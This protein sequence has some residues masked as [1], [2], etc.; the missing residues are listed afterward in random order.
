[1]EHETKQK[2]TYNLYDQKCLDTLICIALWFCGCFGLPSEH[3]RTFQTNVSKPFFSISICDPVNQSICFV[4]KGKHLTQFV[5]DACFFSFPLYLTATQMYLMIK[6]KELLLGFLQISLCTKQGQ[7]G[8][9]FL[10]ISSSPFFIREVV[11]PE[12]SS[13]LNTILHLQDERFRFYQPTSGPDLTRAQVG[14]GESHHQ[15]HIPLNPADGVH[16]L[17]P[18]LG[19]LS[20]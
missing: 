9:D 10:I 11:W 15:F 12:Q 1:M 18:M 2:K 3:T 16:S 14:I 8:I 5:P 7:K 17:F 13:D 6:G 4:K 20:A 19:V